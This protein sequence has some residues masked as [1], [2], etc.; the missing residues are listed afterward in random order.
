MANN[1]YSPGPQTL[2]NSSSTGPG[3]WFRLHPSVRNVTFQ[4]T[5]TG[6]SVGVTVGTTLYVEASNDGVNA[7]ATK[8]ATIAF[9]GASPQSDG[10][11]LDAHYEYVRFNTNSI[12]TGSIVG[13][14]SG[15]FPAGG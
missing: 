1:I 10:F 4:A 14:A 13:V 5:L 2:L 3:S 6:S 15:H 8:L 12:T 9:N 7:L 11:T